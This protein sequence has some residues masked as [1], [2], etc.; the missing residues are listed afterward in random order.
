MGTIE[1]LQSP[2]VVWLIVGVALCLVELVLPTAFIAC[3]MGIS[4]LL[5]AAIAAFLPLGLQVILWMGLSLALVMVSR[6]FVRPSNAAKKLDA[7]E[8]ETLTEIPAGKPGRVRYEGN[9]WLAQCEDPDLAIGP[10]QKVLIVARRGT[11]LIVMPET[12][13]RSLVGE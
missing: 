11:T 12:T 13:L 5:V 2:T 9:S 1:M 3:V 8:A 6:R 7:T 10:H 4:A